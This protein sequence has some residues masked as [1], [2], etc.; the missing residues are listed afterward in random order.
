MV[1]TASKLGLYQRWLK[2]KF[3]SI[4]ALYYSHVDELTQTIGDL[5]EPGV[6]PEDF[7]LTEYSFIQ[8]WE[9][10]MI[11]SAKV[12]KIL[13]MANLENAAK[14]K[15]TK[16]LTNYMFKYD[17]LTV[18]IKPVV[19]ALDGECVEL[20][21]EYLTMMKRFFKKMA[22]I[23]ET[24]VEISWVQ[25]FFRK[26]KGVET[27]TEEMTLNQTIKHIDTFINLP[28]GQRFYLSDQ[29][30]VFDEEIGQ[31][32]RAIHWIFAPR[33]YIELLRV[34]FNVKEAL[35]KDEVEFLRNLIKE[36]E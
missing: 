20:M 31:E 5:D 29:I 25:Q 27:V 17:V 12:Y 3:Q 7:T 33:T 21:V 32:D 19:S 13:D 8:Q 2:N 26:D 1:L 23:D 4:E 11:S 36:V 18:H 14:A 30:I 15:I 34:L 24:Q 6:K 28:A 10:G 22:E 16:R 9:D 35:G